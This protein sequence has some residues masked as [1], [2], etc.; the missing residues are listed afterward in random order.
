MMLDILI[1]KE[2]LQRFSNISEIISRSS[3]TEA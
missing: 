2:Y 1:I 3:D